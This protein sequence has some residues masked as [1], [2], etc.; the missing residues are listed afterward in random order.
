MIEI[1]PN[2]DKA[3]ARASFYIGAIDDNIGVVGMAGCVG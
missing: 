1:E 2:G 3:T